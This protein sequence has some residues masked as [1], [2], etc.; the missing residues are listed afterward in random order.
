MTDSAELRD[1]A[2]DILSEDR[3]RVRHTP[4]PF[5]G[6]LRWLADV[7]A[8][9]GRLLA[10]VG[11]FFGRFGWLWENTVARVMLVVVVVAV[12]A[13]LS[14]VVIRRRRVAAVVRGGGRRDAKAEDPSRLERAAEEAEARGDYAA[15]V[16]LRFQ[17]GVIRLQ[18]A[19]RVRRGRTTATRAIGR[20]LRSDVFDDLGATFDEVAYGGRAATPDDAA[21]ARDAWK[22]V[23]AEASS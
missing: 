7:L 13:A 1:K 4:G 2:R 19:G 17:A 15:G 12:V 16:R 8:P 11:R 3:F 23:L 5:R 9:I 18:D 6:V 14:Q 10:P 22:R 20:Q 21:T